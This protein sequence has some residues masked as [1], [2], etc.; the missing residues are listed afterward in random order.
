MENE[1]EILYLEPDEEITSII[2]KLKNLVDSKSVFLVIPKGASISQSVVNLKLLK[3]EAESLKLKIA[4]VSHDEI[5]KNLAM[6]VGIDVFASINSAHPL[7]KKIKENPNLNDVIEIDMSEKK[8]VTPPPGVK[9]NHYNQDGELIDSDDKISVDK[10]DK[11]PE[12]V[13]HS[14]AS[15]IAVDKY[16]EPKPIKPATKKN[17]KKIII[18]SILIIIVLGSFVYF[19]PSMKII[20]SLKTEPIEENIKITVDTA[21][22]DYSKETGSIPGEIITTNDDINKD[23]TATGKK[24]IGDKAKGTVTISNGTGT[25]TNLPTGSQLES[26]SGLIFTTTASAVV[27][28]AT[29]SVDGG[30]NVVKTPGKADVAVEASKAG[31]DYNIGASTFTVY[32]F[33]GLS[34]NN[35]NSFSGGSSKQITIISGTDIENAK[36]ELKKEA[37]TKLQEKLSQISTDKKLSFIGSAINYETNGFSSDKGEGT[38]TDKFN[39]KMS[40][41]AKTIG[42]NQNDYKQSVINS[43]GS[44]IPQDKELIL[45]SSDEILQGGINADYSKGTLEIDGRIKT[46]LGP[47]LSVDNMPQEFKGKN[48]SYVENSLKSINGITDIK[49]YEKPSWWIKRMPLRSQNIKIEFDYK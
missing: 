1:Q 28:A 30:G 23:F 11:K 4:I 8:V 24:N 26:N 31:E 15:P 36:N 40:L 38:E 14:M 39:A 13:T 32:N 21:T 34:G 10:N 46:K 6:Q 20:A 9:I 12:P 27:P 44:K 19:Y 49:F 29:A 47:K 22:K 41:S 35:S 25:V 2:D 48:Y 3:K 42:F 16:F 45:S 37:E 43:L 5:G 18:I 7:V 17:W 33:S